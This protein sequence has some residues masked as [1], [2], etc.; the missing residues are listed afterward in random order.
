MPVM[1]SSFSM[2][3]NLPL[4][5]K[6]FASRMLNA[7]SLCLIWLAVFLLF[8][9]GPVQG[10][11]PTITSQHN[12]ADTG[13]DVPLTSFSFVLGFSERVQKGT[14]TITIDQGA[15]NKAKPECSGVTFL[16]KMVVVPVTEE[17]GSAGTHTVKV[18][19]TCFK[20]TAGEILAADS[21]HAFTTITKG[22]TSVL[23]HDVVKPG[24]IAGPSGGTAAALDLP[25]P[26][27]GA[28]VA[29]KSFQLRIVFHR[30]I[31]K[32]PW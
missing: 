25:R 20:N 7:R 17:L 24:I 29:A 15:V 1:P 30:R 8:S 13:T 27:N 3:E 5:V 4:H 11:K 2:H 6:P 16:D 32:G 22:S 10:A 14:G 19:S 21:T 18:P 26:L 31:A 23:E 12:P 9:A 28:W